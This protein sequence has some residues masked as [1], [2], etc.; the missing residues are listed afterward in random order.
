[1]DIKSLSYQIR[2]DAKGFQNGMPSVTQKIN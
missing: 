2:G 1:M